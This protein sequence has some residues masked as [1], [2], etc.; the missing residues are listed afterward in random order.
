[1]RQPDPISLP[2]C[3]LLPFTISMIIG[4]SG[5]GLGVGA[6]WTVGVCI[7]AAVTAYILGFRYM[8]LL[9]MAVT[10]GYTVAAISVPAP[11]PRQAYGHEVIC[12][13]VV[14]EMR[15]GDGMRTMIV[16]AD[17][18][19]GHAS[20]VF[21]IRVSVPSYE[22]EIEEC[23]RILFVSELHPLESRTVLPDEVDYD[24]SAIRAGVVA[25][26]IV[27]PDDILRVS[28][29]PGLMNDI[30]RMRHGVASILA[31]GSLPA[32][33]AA[34]LIA[35]LTA[36][37]SLLMPSVR[38]MFATSGLAHVLALSGLHVGILSLFIALILSP[39]AAVGAGRWR[40]PAV[41]A[42]LWGFA[43]MT[44]L[45]ASVVR[46]VLMV[47]L[48][49]LTRLMQRRWSP[50]NA[51]CGAAVVILIFSPRELFSL[52]FQLSFVAVASIILLAEPLN[53]FP[54]ENNRWHAVGMAVTVPV[55]AMLGTGIISAMHFGQ[56][57]LW[58]IP[59]NIIVSFLVPPL[60]WAGVVKVAAGSVGWSMGWLDGFIT[61]V[62]SLIMRSV[63]WVCSM[64]FSHVEGVYVST[65]QCVCWF[66]SL[67]LFTLWVYRRRRVWMVACVLTGLFCTFVPRLEA[68]NWPEDELYITSTHASTCL[69]VRQSDALFALS[70]ARYDAGV[71]ELD[72]LRYSRYMMRRGVRTFGEL[73]SGFR[74]ASLRHY[75]GNAVVHRGT[76]Y[77]LINSNR[78]RYISRLEGGYAVVCRGF[79][80][81]V[82]SLASIV[83][84][85]TILLGSDLDLRRHDRY[86]R[87][88]AEAG[89][90][91]RSLRRK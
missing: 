14:E 40:M 67:G 37:R 74:S 24:A 18:L 16:S 81:D 57:P 26:G 51:L 64:P 15:E 36:D 66:V 5:W 9:P 11:M 2:L 41:V 13:G 50:L 38:D 71:H 77:R 70:S 7:V 30:R 29:E 3:P 85:D 34:F 4:I 62:H 78:I 53:P 72:S 6:I 61:T 27:S 86:M 82:V 54:R 1:M 89:I 65:L 10:A 75:E 58:F 17:S 90:P 48:F 79:T 76:A 47:T 21:M 22:P 33:P 8:A 56:M 59:A 44:G 60:L 73:P 31:D 12:S 83:R 69:L 68:E 49:A 19:G 20:A 42:V 45:S 84:P 63:E 87:E 25:R 23:D 55:A 32:G 43:V 52:G 39:L 88:L 46:S 35:L 91:V 28:P 80:G